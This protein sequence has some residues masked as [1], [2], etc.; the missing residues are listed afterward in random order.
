M[1]SKEAIVAVVS[2][3]CSHTKDDIRNA[4][5]KILIDVQ[6]QTG[7]IQLS[8]LESLPEKV[9]E[10]VW[11]KISATLLNPKVTL[12]KDVKKVEVVAEAETE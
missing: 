12:V 2:I 8:D 1:L 6:K 10:T 9:R 11:E 3:S 4:A 7:A 5:L